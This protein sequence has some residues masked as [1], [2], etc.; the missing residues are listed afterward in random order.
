MR[1]AL[2]S[3]IAMA[4]FV[5]PSHAAMLLNI[6]P[7]NFLPGSQGLWVYQ[8]NAVATA[9]ETIVG[10]SNP[11]VTSFVWAFPQGVWSAHQV[12]TPILDHT[13]ATRQDQ[14]NAAPLWSD[15]WLPYDSY[16]YPTAANSVKIG[17]GTITETRSGT[18]ESLPSAGL[19]PPPT[20]YGTIS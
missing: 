1:N 2:L 4:L 14:L 12:G 16:F 19:G 11:K 20:G 6:N 9:G 10:F 13:T 15:T 8:I 3:P 5:T 18:G 17:L 7:V